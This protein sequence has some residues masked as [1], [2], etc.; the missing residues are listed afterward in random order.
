MTIGTSRSAALALLVG[1][2]T[3]VAGA[4]VAQDAEGTTVPAEGGMSDGAMD[5][6]DTMTMSGDGPG[7]AMSG[8]GS[9]MAMDGMEGMEAPD[10]LHV[11]FGL[12]SARIPTDQQGVLDQAVRTFRG[13]DW[14]VIEI[15][16]VADTVGAPE[17]NLDL[18]FRRARSVYDAL[19]ARGMSPLQLQIR[20]RGNSELAVPTPDGVAEPRNRVAE[21]TWR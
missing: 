11:F 13:G 8:D 18:S 3:V 19:T 12:G 6:A 15:D 17:A 5:G 21:I 1:A 20:A 7:T 10:P 9:D 2:W 4:A 16:G 14:A